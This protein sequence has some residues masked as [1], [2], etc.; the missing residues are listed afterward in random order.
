MNNRKCQLRESQP[1]GSSCNLQLEGEIK[2][3]VV[4]LLCHL[5]FL[6][7]LLIYL[8]LSSHQR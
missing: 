3:H 4:L 1:L 7:M 2:T 5:K 6:I 8:I